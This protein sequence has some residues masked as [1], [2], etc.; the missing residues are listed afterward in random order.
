MY[1]RYRFPTEIISYAVWLY[2]TFPLS[3]R[4]IQKLLMHRGIDVSHET[5]RAWCQKFGQ[6]FAKELRQRR[7]RVTDKWHQG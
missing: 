2:Y 6:R 5:I 4:D 1:Y 3:Y 7:H